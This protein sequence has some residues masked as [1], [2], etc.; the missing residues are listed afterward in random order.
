[1]IA[2]MMDYYKSTPM[3][4]MANKEGQNGNYI[5]GA[6]IVVATGYDSLSWAETM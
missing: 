3:V 6:S 2:S 1:M 5:H 4:R